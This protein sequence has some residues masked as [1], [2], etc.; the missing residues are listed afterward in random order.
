MSEHHCM[1]V[2]V[3]GQE[4]GREAHVGVGKDPIVW[5]CFD[6]FSVQLAELKGRIREHLD[7]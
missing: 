5:L 6:H 4:C 3:G 7:A 1:F 2:S